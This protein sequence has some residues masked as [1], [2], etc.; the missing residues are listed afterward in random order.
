MSTPIDQV[1]DDPHPNDEEDPQMIQELLE[2]FNQGEQAAQPAQAAQQ[3]Q[4]AQQ[5]FQY[6]PEPEQEGHEQEQEQYYEHYEEPPRSVA[7]RI[8]G[9]AKAPLIVL[10]LYLAFGLPLLDRTLTRYIPRIATEAGGMNLIGVLMKAIVV[11]IVF[12]LL[13][14]LV[15]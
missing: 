15:A 10:A 5:Q 4:P 11:T 14:K 12:Y 3:A 7:A 13:N 1:P 9:E 8:W 6:Y 2:Q